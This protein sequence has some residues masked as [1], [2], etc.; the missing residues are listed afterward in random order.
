MSDRDKMPSTWRVLGC[1]M[2][3][4]R[5]PGTLS[6]STTPLHAARPQVLGDL[7]HAHMKWKEW[8]A[9]G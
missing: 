9:Q 8:T 4:R 5:T 6:R 1:T 3:R 2:I 7:T